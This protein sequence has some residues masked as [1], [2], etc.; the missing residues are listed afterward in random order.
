MKMFEP[1]LLT[2][3]TVI[4]NLD[5]LYSVHVTLVFKENAH[6]KHYSTILYTCKQALHKTQ[7]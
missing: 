2:A 1:T 7:Q 4:S 6:R 3:V 5:P